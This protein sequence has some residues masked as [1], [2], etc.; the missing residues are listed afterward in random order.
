M[1]N[2]LIKTLLC[3][4]LILGNTVSAQ[5]W[6]EQDVWKQQDRGFLW[7]PDAKKAP[8]KKRQTQTAQ[9]NVVQNELMQFE[10]LQ[11][12]L[13]SA[14]KIAIMSP[15]E[16]NVKRYIELQE[17]A[18]QKSANFTDQWQRV[19]WTNP[20][21]DYSQHS[22][23]TNSVALQHYDE[24]RQRQKAQ[25]IRQLAAENGI[26]FIFRSDCPYCHAMAP[27]LKNFADTY[28]IN[29][30]PVSTDGGGMGLFP[31]PLP[32][33]GIVQRLGVTTV[34]AM[35]IMDTKTKQFKP[36]GFGVMAQTDLEDRFLAYSR[37]VG[38]LY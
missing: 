2:T 21:L 25:A 13:E 8:K 17:L 4:A 24:N 9:T 33:N 38:T 37:P 19:I 32:N 15:S 7:Y 16:A 22:R 31:S 29:I 10:Q 30:M 36:I 35:F 20:Q 1:M 27:I 3:V 5:N 26:L 12:N 14:R 23:P 6:Y 18:M 11:K 34:P 28:G